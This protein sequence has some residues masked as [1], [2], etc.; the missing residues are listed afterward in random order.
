MIM[1]TLGALTRSRQ[2]KSPHPFL[3]YQAIVVLVSCCKIKQPI[4][5]PC[6]KITIAK[7]NIV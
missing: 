4:W 2:I 3:G 7:N 5:Y 6:D 1:V